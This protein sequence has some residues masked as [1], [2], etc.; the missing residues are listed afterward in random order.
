[1]INETEEATIDSMSGIN[2]ALKVVSVEPLQEKSNVTMECVFTDSCPTAKWTKNGKVLTTGP[3]VQKES[4]KNIARVKI[5]ELSL[6]DSGEYTV[7][8]GQ[9][10]SSLTIDVAGS[11]FNGM[12]IFASAFIMCDFII[13]T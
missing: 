10:K 9:Y 12:Q 1:M 8:L 13:R 11:V 5:K 6:K 3:R 2:S 4:D 7:T